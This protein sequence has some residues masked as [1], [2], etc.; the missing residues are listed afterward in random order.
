MLLGM[1]RIISRC[2]LGARESL[3]G[4]RAG[5]YN[6]QVRWGGGVDESFP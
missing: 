1:I 3:V 4:H 2:A 6:K 5:A